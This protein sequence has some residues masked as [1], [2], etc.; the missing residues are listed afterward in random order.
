MFLGDLTW[1]RN[2][3]THL[4][5]IGLADVHK[6]C[7]SVFE[8]R[9]IFSVMN[10]GPEEHKKPEER[11]HFFYSACQFFLYL[12]SITVSAAGCSI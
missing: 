12:L 2:I 6:L 7:T 5:F 4:M 8:P 11:M 10:I 9:N 1:P 3:R